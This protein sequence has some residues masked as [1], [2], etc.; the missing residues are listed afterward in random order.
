MCDKKKV[1]KEIP[2]EWEQDSNG[3]ITRYAT[4]FVIQHSENEFFL[5]FYEVRPPLVLGNDQQ[6]KERLESIKT[7]K[8]ECVGRI[9]ISAKKIPSIIGAIQTNYSNYIKSSQP[10]EDGK[11]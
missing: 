5:S 9:A 7:V 10:E 2:V 1:A 3:V 6:V 11:E 4:N 8:A